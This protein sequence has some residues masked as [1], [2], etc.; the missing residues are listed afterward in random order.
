MT[1][2][3]EILRKKF[4]ACASQEWVNS[5]CNVGLQGAPGENYVVIDIDC[6][7]QNE[8]QK[9]RKKR[10]ITGRRADLLVIAEGGNLNVPLVIPIEI[11]NKE[12]PGIDDAV[13]QLKKFSKTCANWVGNRKCCF[14]P[15]LAC[16][17]LRQSAKR[18]L[19]QKRVAFNGKNY[20]IELIMCDSI[21]WDAFGIKKAIGG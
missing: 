13:D 19:M 20:P 18:Q 2:I 11:K 21:L 17:K 5:A 15:V 9:K 4:S 7:S 3:T 1:G 14:F 12:N 6:V 8:I 10:E 16:R